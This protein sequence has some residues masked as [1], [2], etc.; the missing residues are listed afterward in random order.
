[1]K[2]CLLIFLLAILSGVF[3]HPVIG[4]SNTVHVQPQQISYEQH[5]PLSVRQRMP[6][7][8]K[9]C[10]F[11]VFQLQASEERLALHLFDRNGKTAAK[12]RLPASASYEERLTVVPF[13]FTVDLFEVKQRRGNGTGNY[14]FITTFP[15]EYSQQKYLT[16]SMFGAQFLWLDPQQQRRPILIL[17]N[18]I[19]SDCGKAGNSILAVFPNGWTGTPTV[20]NFDYNASLACGPLTQSSMNGFASDV[21]ANGLVQFVHRIWYRDDAEKVTVFRWNGEKFASVQN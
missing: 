18:F 13:N 12:E 9:S 14:R 7:E 16:P 10:F 3:P 11:G 6:P 8:A 5:V 15:L 20:Q 1:M 4:D 17:D 2:Y 21:D 19:R